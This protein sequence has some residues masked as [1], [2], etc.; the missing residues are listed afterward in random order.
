[1]DIYG[2][3]VLVARVDMPREI[4]QQGQASISYL[5]WSLMAVGLVF[6]AITLLLL[7][8]QVLSRLTRLSQSVSEIGNNGD[9]S[10][11]VL[12]G[13]RDELSHLAQAINTLLS[14]MEQSERALRE[15]TR[16]NELILQTS[17]DGFMVLDING[18]LREANPAFCDILGYPREELL[19]LL[20]SDLEVQESATEATKRRIE[21]ISKTGA[22]RFETRYCRQGGQLVDVEVSINFVKFGQDR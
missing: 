7:E 20:L 18:Q 17:L 9:L 16:R 4:Y 10:A 11:R 3:P 21:A 8:N 1:R 2:H 22:D 15:Q 6:G 12:R 19:G 5:M 13:G 14:S